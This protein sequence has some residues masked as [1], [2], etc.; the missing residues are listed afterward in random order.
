MTDFRRQTQSVHF[1]CLR[2]NH[3]MRL[4]IRLSPSLRSE[5]VY[6]CILLSSYLI[7]KPCNTF[8]P[9]QNTQKPNRLL[10]GVPPFLSS[11]RC[12]LHWAGI[13]FLEGLI[14]GFPQ[15]IYTF[16]FLPHL[17]LCNPLNVSTLLQTPP[18]VI[19]NSYT[20]ETF[21]V[22]LHIMWAPWVR[23]FCLVCSVTSVPRT[24]PD[25]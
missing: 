21:M 18:I 8:F 5:N 2:G 22:S 23:E 19:W 3:P 17:L 9:G 1:G 16:S 6:T 10:G 7:L 12:P 20:C 24:G 13:S 25:T 11:D 4:E 15:D 14:S